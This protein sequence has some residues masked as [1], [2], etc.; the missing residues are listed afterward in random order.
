[1]KVYLTKEIAMI[2]DPD[3][4]SLL[5][6][7]EANR[8]RAAGP[9]DMQRNRP[10]LGQNHTTNGLRGSQVVEGLTMRD[11]QDCMIRGYILAHS[12]YKDNSRAIEQLETNASIA[13]EAMKG[14]YAKLNA[15]D[16]FDLVGNVD[17]LAVIQNTMCEIEKSWGFS[18]TR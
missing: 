3:L 16:M 9:K 15:N 14:P 18:Q 11:L 13:R 12:T 2:Q 17:P 4:T 8:G 5:D 7:L 6:Q 1:M 10:Y